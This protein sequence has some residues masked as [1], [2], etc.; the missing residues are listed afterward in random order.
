MKLTDWIKKQA[1]L[2]QKRLLPTHGKIRHSCILNDMAKDIGLNSWNH[3]C[4]YEK[5]PEKFNITL[6]YKRIENISEED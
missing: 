2:R 1:R 4:A 3:L 6:D 5:N